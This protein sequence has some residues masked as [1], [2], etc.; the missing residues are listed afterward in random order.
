MQIIHVWSYVWRLYELR[1]LF[2]SYEYFYK[3]LKIIAFC[4]KKFRFF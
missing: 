4:F 1:E 3:S 2:R